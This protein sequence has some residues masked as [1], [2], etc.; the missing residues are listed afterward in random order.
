MAMM[1]FEQR[2]HFY[3]CLLVALGISR[4]NGKLPTVRRKNDFMLKWLRNA[5]NNHLFSSEILSEIEWLR[6][7]IMRSGPDTDAEPMLHFIYS[8]AR[9]AHVFG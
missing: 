7:K 1:H 3:F 9:T 6:E 8:T 2:L 5:Q 4:H